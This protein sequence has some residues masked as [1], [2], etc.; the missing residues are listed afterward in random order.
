MVGSINLM[1]RVG[2]SYQDDQWPPEQSSTVRSKPRGDIDPCVCCFRSTLGLAGLI[3][4]MLFLTKI[5]DKTMGQRVTAA[6]DHLLP[7][8]DVPDRSQ[9]AVQKAVGM[10]RA[11]LAAPVDNRRVEMHALK[12]FMVSLDIDLLAEESS[13]PN[14]GRDVVRLSLEYGLPAFVEFRVN[15]YQIPRGKPLLE[16]ALANSDDAWFAERV[17]LRSNVTASYY[18]AA[19]AH[20]SGRAPSKSTKALVSQLSALE[21]E[22]QTFMIKEKERLDEHWTFLSVRNILDPAEEQKKDEFERIIKEYSRGR[23]TDDDGV[24]V[25]SNAHALLKLLVTSGREAEFHR[26]VSW[27]IVRQLAG[28][29]RSS[30]T[31]SL[32][33]SLRIWY[34]CVVKVSQLRHSSWL[35]SLSL[36]YALTKLRAMRMANGLPHDMRNAR[37]MDA[38]FAEFPESPSGGS[39]WRAWLSAARIVNRL[40]V[41]SNSSSD[42]VFTSGSG[43]AYY[44]TVLNEVFVPAGMIGKPVFYKQGPAAHNYGVI[45]MVSKTDNLDRH[46]SENLADFVGSLV[47]HAA[48]SSLPDRLRRITVPGNSALNLTSEQLYFVSRCVI[49]CT[50]IETRYQDYNEG[51]HAA[52]RA[53]C[54]VPAM[55]M[56]SFGEAFNCPPGSQMNPVDKCVF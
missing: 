22:V 34:K 54:N 4:V 41:I 20:Y 27:S 40:G 44:G 8:V 49:W 26:L 46:S 15:R 52:Y 43:V 53:R 2:S 24:Y 11:C 37:D 10:F 45:G 3:V 18:S 6:A 21:D 5:V 51:S 16:V 55:N 35:D 7:S 30:E 19:I 56:P 36:Q 13:D 31:F 14:P 39:F 9:T 48:F 33:P 32:M 25:N 38:R 23:Y 50:R 12:D 47:S 29:G 28:F 1:E 17:L 42:I